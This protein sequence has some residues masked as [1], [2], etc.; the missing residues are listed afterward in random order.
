MS[1]IKILIVED[2]LLTATDI[3]EKLTNIGYEVIGVVQ[4]S[5]EA[6][7]ITRSKNPDIIIMDIKISGET[8]GIDTARIILEEWSGPII[9]LT[10]YSHKEAVDRAKSLFPAAYLLK[11]FNITQFGIHLEMAIANYINQIPNHKGIKKQHTV[12]DA[13]FISVNQV[14]QK[15]YK[16]DIFFIE[17]AGSY[18]SIQTKNGKHLISTNL[19][20]LDKQLDDPTFVR[21]HRKYIVNIHMVERIEGNTIYLQQYP[22]SLPIGDIYKQNISLH[23]Q[24]ITTK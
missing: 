4:N 19:K 18:I 13:I 6:I 5:N 24:I 11:P 10:A 20:N 23:L 21:I 17:A 3:E 14:Y 8:D 9:F 12:S 7:R 16:R 1:K 15:I 2:E 22:E